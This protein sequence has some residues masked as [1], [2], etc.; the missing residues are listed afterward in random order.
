MSKPH[1]SLPRRQ[2]PSIASLRALEAVDRLGSA[3]AAAQE[4]NLTQGAVSR[5]LQ[6]L[7]EQLGS[8]LLLRQ[9]RS[10]DLTPA[11][12]TYAST[13][14]GALHTISQA[15]VSLQM[16]P[17]G[18]TLDLAIL[19]SFGMQWLMPRLPDFARRH[20]EVTLN[21]TTRLE[22]FNFAADRFDAALHFKGVDWPDTD[23]IA[24]KPE[25]MLAVAA[26][27]LISAP[28][29][30]SPRQ[31]AQMPL[32]H[33]QT[34]KNA[35]QTWLSD[36]DQAPNLLPGALFDQFTTIIQAALHGMGAALLP[37]YLITQ[38]L[39]SGT[40]VTLTNEPARPMGH[41]HLVWPSARP[42][43]DSLIKFRDWIS[44]QSEDE[45]ILPR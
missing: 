28:L 20:P 16:S 25:C 11:A 19:P 15:A 9:H 31:I 8:Q 23:S 10:L 30:L 44:T 45:D 18:G 4:L 40:L 22:P 2:F 34:R 3:T 42:P 14:R 12:R 39:A 43:S 6:T 5:Q 27:E 13:V 41:Y 21:M 37:D 33:I 29:P 1:T 7:E 35:W 26:P 24:L 32:L 36:A 38:E 17:Q